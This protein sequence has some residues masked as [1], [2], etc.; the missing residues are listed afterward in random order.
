[1]TVYMRDSKIKRC[2]DINV[3]DFTAP[4]NE[5][6]RCWE[7]PCGRYVPEL[8]AG[9]YTIAFTLAKRYAWKIECYKEKIAEKARV[10]V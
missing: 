7:F 8:F 5:R 3:G 2:S 9:A 1:M 10:E 4:W 6:D